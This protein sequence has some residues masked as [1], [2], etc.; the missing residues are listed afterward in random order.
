MQ[1]QCF[2]YAGQLDDG[3]RVKTIATGNF[4]ESGI[5]LIS[6]MFFRVMQGDLMSLREVRSNTICELDG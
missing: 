1:L 2:S 6:L 5:A 3:L 4:G